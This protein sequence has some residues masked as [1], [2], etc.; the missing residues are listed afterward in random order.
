MQ[1]CEP[2]LQDTHQL[3][4]PFRRL[5]LFQETYAVEQFH[6]ESFGNAYI[7]L[8]WLKYQSSVPSLDWLFGPICFAKKIAHFYLNNTAEN[9]DAQI[10]PAIEAFARGAKW[11]SVTIS[12]S[13]LQKTDEEGSVDM[14]AKRLLKVNYMTEKL[15]KSFRELLADAK[16][17]VVVTGGAGNLGQKILAYLAKIKKFRVVVLDKVKPPASNPEEEWI[18]CDL[19]IY[20]NS[21]AARLQGAHSV[22]M[23]AAKNPFPEASSGDAFAS[24]LINSNVLEVILFFLVVVVGG[25]GPRTK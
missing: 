13:H 23:L 19:S 17:L 12:Y 9:W 14:C 15:F 16:P 20:A 8:Q 5:D 24:M 7:N 22:I 21:W 2:I 10:V 1:C 4:T 11:A 18:V 3:V 25:G 6:S